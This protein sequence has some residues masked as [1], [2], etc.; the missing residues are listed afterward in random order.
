MV[1]LNQMLNQAFVDPGLRSHAVKSQNVSRLKAMLEL[2]K[3]EP[4]IP[5]LP[6]QLDRHPML[7]N[8]PNG[9]VDL[10]TGTLREPRREDYLTKLCPTEH[11]PDATCPLW[12]TTLAKIFKGNDQLIGYV[13]QLL[14]YCLTGDVREQIFPIFWGSGANGKSTIIN[15]ILAMLGDDYAIKASRDLFLAI[16]GDKHPT[17]LAQLHGKRLV[18]CVE[19]SDAARLDEALV[20]EMTGGDPISARRMREDYWTFYPTHKT[21]LVTNHRPEIRGTDEGIWRRQRLIPFDVRIPDA[22]QDKQLSEK[23]KAELPGILA[24]C[25]RG[26]LEWQKNGLGTPDAVMAATKEYRQDQ[27]V[28]ARFVSECCRQ[29]QRDYAVKSSL[30]YDAYKKW[31]ERSGEPPVKLRQFGAAMTEKGFERY[32]N[33]GVWYRGVALIDN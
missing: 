23:L 13:Q 22:E 1:M 12:L 17:T 5:I 4:G 2:A 29:G 16:K 25:V 33:N 30:L 15:I 31:A 32:T 6:D 27:D 28:L 8:C 9:T 7:L 21:I 18:V 3:S 19:T 26:C 14:G 11:H 20:K 10:L 24:W